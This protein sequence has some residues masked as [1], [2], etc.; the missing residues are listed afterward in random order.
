M[1]EKGSSIISFISAV[2]NLFFLNKKKKKARRLANRTFLLF[3]NNMHVTRGHEV[4]KKF[5]THR[6]F[7][8]SRRA[9]YLYDIFYYVRILFVAILAGLFEDSANNSMRHF[10]MLLIS[11]TCPAS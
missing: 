10:S 7:N 2:L 4:R 3:P 1:Y 9:T 11:S 6:I 8:P 5:W